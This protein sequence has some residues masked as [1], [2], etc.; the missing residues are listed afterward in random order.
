MFDPQS[1]DL[2]GYRIRFRDG[3]IREN[4]LTWV[5]GVEDEADQLIVWWYDSGDERRSAPL[6]LVAAVEVAGIRPGLSLGPGM[7]V[8]MTMSTS[9]MMD[10]RRSRWIEA[11]KKA[12]GARKPRV[13]S[14]EARARMSRAQKNRW[15]RYHLN[16]GPMPNR[17]K[18]E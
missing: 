15:M 1:S 18:E 3:R 2:P 14:P 4:V 12:G 6:D 8:T 17:R 7:R 9:R 5:L 16:Q 11:Q 10:G 13:I